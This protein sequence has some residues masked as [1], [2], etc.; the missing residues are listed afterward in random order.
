MARRAR[1]GAIERLPS[2]RFRASYPHPFDPRSSARIKA[3]STF[4]TKRAAEA[5]LASERTLIE[6]GDWKP[7][8]QRTDE[9]RK[10]LL[11]PP[12]TK[13]SEEWLRLR[14]LAPSTRATYD[15][16]IENHLKPRWGDLPLSTITPSDVRRWV[17]AELTYL[18][19]DMRRKVY[20]L[21]A[22]IM[23]TAALDDYI[24]AS[25]CRE[26]MVRPQQG[27]AGTAPRNALTVKELWTL[28]DAV[29]PYM[30]VLVLTMGLCA[31]RG[32]EARELRRGDLDLESGMMTV[33]R[34]VTG[35]GKNVVVGAPKTP[36]SVRRPVIPPVLIPELR[37]QLR[38]YAG[39][40]TRALVFPH[41]NDRERHIPYGTFNEHIRLAVQATGITPIT[42]HDLRRTALTLVGQHGASIGDLKTY[43]GHRTLPMVEL[44]QASDVERQRA[45]AEHVSQAME[46][47]APTGVE[48]AAAGGNVLDFA[49]IRRRKRG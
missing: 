38:A 33:Q 16:Y 29:P 6:R 9:E 2:Q 43:G 4:T 44:Y 24:S 36:G 34:G 30:R 21:F 28:A 5:W 27:R 37:Q 20:S 35:Q 49:A 41:P 3:P 23:R 39:S 47:A 15:S 19:K 32:G 12:F 26:G 1:W 13:Y 17:N 46:A 42:P 10:A 18:G 31:L 14:T 48:E 8:H 25:P 7:P 11:D 40:G 22:T 45:L